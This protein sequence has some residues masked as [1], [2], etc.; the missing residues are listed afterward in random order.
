MDYFFCPR[1]VGC[2]ELFQKIT[3]QG[4]GCKILNFQSTLRKMANCPNAPW[5]KVQ[6][7]YPFDLELSVPVRL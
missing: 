7:K 5:K 4:D 1:L 6:K 2:I 3:I